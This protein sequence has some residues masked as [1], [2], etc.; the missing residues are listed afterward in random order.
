MI[1]DNEAGGVYVAAV[2]SPEF[3]RNSFLTVYHLRVLN[4]YEGVQL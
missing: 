2:W 4:I 1:F 3:R